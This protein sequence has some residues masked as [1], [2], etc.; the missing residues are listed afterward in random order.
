MILRDETKSPFPI[1]HEI[2]ERE[3]AKIEISPDLPNSTTVVSDFKGNKMSQEE[4]KF[5][6]IPSPD[7]GNRK[8]HDFDNSA[9]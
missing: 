9:A 4:T 3:D 6:A 8:F 2:M 5:D 1:N 7:L